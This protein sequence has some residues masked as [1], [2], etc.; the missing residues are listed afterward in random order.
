L[1]LAEAPGALE[2]GYAGWRLIAYRSPHYFCFIAPQQDH[3]RL[4]FEH[5]RRLPDPD[6]VLEPMGKQVRFV[7]LIP[8]RRIPKAAVRRLIRAALRT[9]PERKVSSRAK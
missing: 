6:G 9:L 5:G 2:A 7:R 4:G 1:V 3:V 8:G